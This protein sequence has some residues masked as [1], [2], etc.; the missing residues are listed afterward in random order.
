M[1][2]FLMEDVLE[3]E[4]FTARHNAGES[5]GPALRLKELLELIARSKLASAQVLHP[6]QLQFAKEE[7]EQISAELVHELLALSLRDSPNYG[8]TELRKHIARLHPQASVENVLVT[9]GTSEALYLAFQVLQPKKV[10]LIV[11]GFQL[12][13]ELVES[14]QPLQ[15]SNSF[16]SPLL[17]LTLRWNEQLR[18]EA[19]EEEW[20]A[21]IDREKP[22]T[23]LINHPHNPSGWL[24][25]LGFLA[26]IQDLA[27]GVGARILGDE[28]YRFLCMPESVKQP[29]RISD[30]FPLGPTLFE[31]DGSTLVTGSFIKCLG[32]PGLRIGWCV[33]PK[34][35]IDKMQSLKNY[36]THTVNPV[37]EWLSEHVLRDA[38]L[39]CF[40][41]AHELWS[42]NRALV[43]DWAAMQ[44]EKGWRCHAPQGGWVTALSHQSF[45]QKKQKLA[46]RLKERGC[47]LL[48]LELMELNRFGH[49][50]CA[51]KQR[52]GFRLGLGMAHQELQQLLDILDFES[53]QLA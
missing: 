47:F 37:S 24:P 14:A 6:N 42:K 35:L 44:P 53:K 9:T 38:S 12:L 33:G 3:R 4:R 17:A 40:V 7:V 5:G 21:Q 15:Q 23:I 32:T 34:E 22:D 39:P 48:D 46:A 36:T 11:P 28:H 16:A 51:L 10:A 30:N 43:Q 1:R 26:R 13:T 27:R 8:I 18:P 49:S 2:P 25:S 45:P 20:L 50:S 29:D 41:S 19:Q 52:G 31:N